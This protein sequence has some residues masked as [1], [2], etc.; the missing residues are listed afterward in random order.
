MR[1]CRDCGTGLLGTSR[2]RRCEACWTRNNAAKQRARDLRRSWVD[3][4]RAGRNEHRRREREIQ[5]FTCIRCELLKPADQ[6]PRSAIKRSAF[7]C[8]A[9]RV[10]DKRRYRRAKAAKEGRRLLTVGEKLKLLADYNARVA[11]EAEAR[12]AVERRLR[13]ERSAK[14]EAEWEARR[15]ELAHAKRLRCRRCEKTKPRAKYHPSTLDICKS[16]VSTESAETF[17]R[18]SKA[19]T[20]RYMRQLLTKHGGLRAKDVPSVLVEAKRVQLMIRRAV[21]PKG[22]KT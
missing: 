16:C 4:S 15:Q 9:C 21:A 7:L 17:K 2:R 12:N 5:E 10:E 1:Y 11:A 13:A 19:L 14:R 18:N 22:A 20:D 8:R 3:G 6:Y